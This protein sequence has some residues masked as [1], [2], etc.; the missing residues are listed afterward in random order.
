MRTLR[1]TLIVLAL[2]AHI[3]AAADWRLALPGW[4]Y[5]F[6]R[7]HRAHGEFKTEW[8]YF[9][10]TLRAEDGHRFG[11]QLTFFRQGVRPPGATETTSRFIVNDLKFA[12]F[13]VSDLSAGHFH[14]RQKI[15]RGSF[16]EAGFESRLA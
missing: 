15:A 12:H 5:E 6:P 3:C 14:F 9:T 8:W 4:D 2:A 13:A 16:G 7:D 10:G 11:Y 1:R